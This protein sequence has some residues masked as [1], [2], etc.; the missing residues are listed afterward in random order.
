MS[1]YIHMAI[2]SKNNCWVLTELIRLCIHRQSLDRKKA[3]EQA[4]FGDGEGQG[5]GRRDQEY[6]DRSV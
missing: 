2:D 5:M 3:L 4:P 6:A 1:T